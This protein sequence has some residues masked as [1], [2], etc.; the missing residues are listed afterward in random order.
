M[1]ES[2]IY[3]KDEKSP[4][5]GFVYNL[6]STGQLEYK[7]KYKDGKPN[8]DLIYWYDN[9]NKMRQGKLKD[10]VPIG[11]WEYYNLEGR[12][13]KYIIYDNGKKIDEMKWQIFKPK[14]SDIQALLKSV[15]DTSDLSTIDTAKETFLGKLIIK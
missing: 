5:S 8:G 7:G 6:Y 14:K 2:R 1:F 12:V 11:R 4:F 9:G 15:I 13:W 10:G 3:K